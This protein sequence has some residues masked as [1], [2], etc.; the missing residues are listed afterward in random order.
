MARDPKERPEIAE[1]IRRIEGSRGSVETQVAQLRRTLDI[2]SRIKHSVSH[3]PL[4]WFG[5]SMGVGLL[6]SRVFRRRKKAKPKAKGIIGLLTAALLTMIKPAIRG[7][8]VGELQ[9]RLKG[10]TGWPHPSQETHLPL[11]KSPSRPSN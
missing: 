9:R 4:A 2:P 6:A 10:H 5:S 1:L 11:S 3:N 8:I 7:L